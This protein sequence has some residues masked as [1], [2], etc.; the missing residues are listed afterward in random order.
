MCPHSLRHVCLHS[1][2]SYDTVV[3]SKTL[4]IKLFLANSQAL[5]SHE[6]MQPYE[7]TI[8]LMVTVNLNDYLTTCQGRF[9]GIVANNLEAEKILDGIFQIA[10]SWINP[11]HDLDSVMRKLTMEPYTNDELNHY[12]KLAGSCLD[13]IYQGMCKIGDEAELLADC[14]PSVSREIGD[15]IHPINVMYR[16]VSRS[17]AEFEGYV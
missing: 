12:M 14:E 11:L 8:A 5:F 9:R 3:F 13:M 6:S 16:I 1:L 10:E 7:D 17:I 2:R 4:P 15:L